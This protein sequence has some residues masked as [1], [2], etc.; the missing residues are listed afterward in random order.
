MGDHEMAAGVINRLNNA[1]VINH[2]R[3][4]LRSDLVQATI[5]AIQSRKVAAAVTSHLIATNNHGQVAKQPPSLNARIADSL[6]RLHQFL[7]N[8]AWQVA[9]HLAASSY[10]LA[11]SVLVSETET[12]T[13][14][15]SVRLAWW[16]NIGV[17]SGTEH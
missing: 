13:V 3:A 12:S 2:V 6:V 10:T 16:I 9:Q 17:P 15:R 8:R 11:L 14:P 5:G 1:G 7:R 4:R